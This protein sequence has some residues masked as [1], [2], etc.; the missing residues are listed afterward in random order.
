MALVVLSVAVAVFASFVALDIAGRLREARGRARL[1]WLALAACAMGGGIWAMHFIAM[2]SFDLGL[3]VRYD[4]SLTVGSLLVAIVV[5]GAGLAIA[6]AGRR[7]RARLALGGVLMGL[8]VAA[9][10]YVGM[11]AMRMDATIDY[12]PALFALSVAIAIVAATAALW[13]AFNVQAYWQKLL[14]AAVMAVA[15]SGMHF[16]GM[17][18]AE[19]HL[20]LRTPLFA[21]GHELSP[22]MMGALIGGTTFFLLLLGLFSAIADR[23]LSRTSAMAARRLEQNARR[24]RSLIRNSSDVIAII[25]ARGE[26]AY[27]SESAKRILGFAP[28]WL[29]GR[30]L[31]EFM[32]PAALGEFYAFLARVQQEDG[33]NLTSDIQL[34][35]ADGDWRAFEIT[36]C[37]LARDPSIGG[38]V[39]N[40]RDMSE[41]Q[42]TLDELRAAKDLADK[43]NRSKSAFLAA[44]SH[45][46]RTPLNAIIGFSEVM[47]SGAFGD[48]ASPRILDYAK[49]IEDSGKHL[50][51]LINDILD[52]S[53]AESGKMTLLEDYIRPA[54]VVADSLRLVGA[55]DGKVRASFAVAVAADLPYLYG[56]KRRV[57][58]ILINILANA[59]KFTEAG[60][61]V[62]LSAALDAGTG[63][64]LFTVKDS[65]IGMSAD[66]IL[67][68]LEPFRQ[69]DSRL[70]RKYEGTGLGL[71]LSKHLIELHGGRLE[72]VSA[73]GVGTTVTVRF[74]AARL[75]ATRE[76]DETPAFDLDDAPRASA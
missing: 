76:P 37:N 40:L 68:A 45:E 54:D 75:H 38:I 65:G 2:L 12:D 34:R 48:D 72:I 14:S 42:R 64:L 49:H 58:Q 29:S 73:P 44:M 30:R 41:R 62:S 47:R 18:A 15:V 74:P 9:M 36:C 46:L 5:T 50:L 31:D 60:G 16:V 51:S 43:A 19:Y 21:I 20:A 10:H 23:R 25:D 70:S 63:D 33:V 28:S 1:W 7:S 52:L 55:H 22:P 66:E 56:D 39:A 11:M 4:M 24:Y 26:F 69:V 3:P 13:L 32:S 61:R 27:C 71:P 67:L 6:G 35:H 53:K 57:R 59:F 17:A 8:G